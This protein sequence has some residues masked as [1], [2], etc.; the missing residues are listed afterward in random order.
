MRLLPICVQFWFCLTGAGKWV[1]TLLTMLQFETQ[2]L[3]G[4]WTV[5]LMLGVQCDGIS[6]GRCRERQYA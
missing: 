5:C 6:S 1:R 4:I 2:R 3:L